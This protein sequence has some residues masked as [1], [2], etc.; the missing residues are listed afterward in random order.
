MIVLSDTTQAFEL[1]TSAAV[2]V[3]WSVTYLDRTST[4]SVANGAYG[5][6]ATATTTIIV[7]A[8]GAGVTRLIKDV[9]IVNR[10]TLSLTVRPKVDISGTERFLSGAF[11]LAAGESL[12]YT[13][14]DGWHI[15]DRA[16]RF[17][18][19]DAQSSGSYGQMIPFYK[20]GSAPEAA[21]T[22]YCWSKD[23]GLP[24][25]WS[26]G[27]PGLN[28]RATDGM[29]AADNGC[30]R[31]WTPSGS[32]YITRF[33]PVGTV[34]HFAM[35]WDFLWVN[36]GIVVTTTT[37]QTITP[38]ALPARDIN[39]TTS[40]EG[41]EAG[42]LVT[43]ATTN[44][45]AVTNT[46]IS[47]TNS[48]GVAGRTGTML[49]FPQSAVI[50]TIVPFQLQA[51]DRGVQSVQSVTLGTSYVAGSVSLVLFRRCAD[52][53]VALANVGSPYNNLDQNPGVRIYNS[54]CLLNVGLMSATTSTTLTG[55]VYVMER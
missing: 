52:N 15:L 48:N 55:S 22:F 6:I 18:V 40:G 50:G 19:A 32:L 5:N 9:S 41:V 3:D 34:A 24:G 20:I 11:S 45:A 51:G 43:A 28:G 49:S 47:Y 29:T 39:G 16:G 10:G 44:G 30:I 21:G 27:T 12:Q 7:A 33:N 23:T 38:V 2:S 4:A 1:E 53:A 37:A 46:T 25:A 42:I 31:L 36:T 8:P 54:S 13:D 35:L 26:P 17:R 14:N